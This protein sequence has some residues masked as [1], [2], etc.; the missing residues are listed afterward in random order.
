[1]AGWHVLAIMLH[2]LECHGTAPAGM[3]IGLSTL[4][5]ISQNTYKPAVCLWPEV[6]LSTQTPISALHA[7]VLGFNET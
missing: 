2:Q 4:H 1:M 3:C 5:L 7:F 6:S